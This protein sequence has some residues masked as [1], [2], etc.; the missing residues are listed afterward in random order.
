MTLFDVICKADFPLWVN[1]NEDETNTDRYEDFTV[2]A[3]E[4]FTNL[5]REVQYITTDGEGELVIE[6]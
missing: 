2:C 4:Q 3:L 1:D 6:I 5:E